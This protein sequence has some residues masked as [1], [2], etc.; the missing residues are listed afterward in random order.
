M[1]TSCDGRVPDEGQGVVE[2]VGGVQPRLT[3]VHHVRPISLGQLHFHK[4]W[5]V[6][7]EGDGG[8]G[9]DID[10]EPPGVGYGLGDNPGSKV[11]V[12]FLNRYTVYNVSVTVFH[13]FSKAWI[14]LENSLLIYKILIDYRRETGGFAR[15]T[16]FSIFFFFNKTFPLS[17]TF[18]TKAF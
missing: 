10:Q 5:Y 18:L 1:V 17:A 15:F 11:C 8:D 6:E 7:C 4:L 12:Q 9:Q 3:R 13:S 2:D 16:C 14:L